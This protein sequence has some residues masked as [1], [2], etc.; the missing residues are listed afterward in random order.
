M[1]S[2]EHVVNEVKRIVGEYFK[3]FESSK[4]N[5]KYKVPLMSRLY[6]EEEIAEVV[7]T[8]LNPDK[9]TLNASGD[10]KIEKFENL[11]ANF[12]GTKNGIM[13]NS[14]S[15]ANLVSFLV[16]TNPLIKNRLRPGDEVITPALTYNATVTPLHAT[17]LKPVFVDV[18]LEDYSM[19]TEQLKEALTDKTKAIMIV[20]L[21]GFPVNMTEVMEFAKENNLYVIEDCCEAHGAEWN[22][23][24]VGS[25]G[26]MSTLSFYLS[27]HITTIEGG[28]IMTNNDELAELARIIRSQ[29]VMRN[30]KSQEYKN[31]INSQYPNIDPRFLFANTGYNFRPTEMEGAIGLIQSKRFHDFA[32]ARNNIAEFYTKKLSK[33]SNFIRLPIVKENSKAAWFAYPIMVKQNAPFKTQELTSF[34]EKNSIETRP[35]MSGDY[36]AHPVNKLYEHKIIGDIPNTKYIHKNAFFIGVHAGIGEEEKNHVA[37]CFEEF[38]SK[39]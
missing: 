19:K 30:V 12:I 13:V 18:N 2:K 29:G 36:T 21:L 31:K 34:L 25:F 28:M 22:G 32:K 38:F 1:T 20:H 26:D 39:Y 23:A 10:L 35:I 11:W 14:G 24:K 27:H 15:S 9:L 3:E 37:S 4:K 17:H 6:D 5:S 7:D 33:Y 8:L 16:L